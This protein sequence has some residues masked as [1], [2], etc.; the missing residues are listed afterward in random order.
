VSRTARHFGYSRPTVYRWLTRFDRHRLETLEDRPSRPLRRRRPTWTLGE[1]VAVRRLRLA[2]PRWGK[3]KLAVLL[4]R[5]GIVLSVSRVGRILDRLRATG[6]LREPRGRPIS[7]RHRGW[8]RPHAVRKPAGFVA[9]HP[10]DLVQLDT[11]DVRPVPGLVLKQ[12]TARDVVSRWD[13][14]ELR[15]SA[16]ARAT[17]AILDALADRM[18]FGVRARSVDNG[19]EFMAEFEAACQARGIALFTLPPRSPKLNGR[20]ERANRTHTAEFYEVTDAEPTL[21]SLRPALL[22]WETTYTTI[23]PHQAL[24]YLT[25][26]EY[27]ASLGLEV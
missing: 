16:S 24:G 12:F 2:Y 26:A 22:A 4:R 5:E 14:L 11:L 9:R 13:V 23:R 19:S 3:D 7:A 17:L 6:E 25:P 1:L 18:P 20:V 27:L 15:S 21:A 8:R 10:G